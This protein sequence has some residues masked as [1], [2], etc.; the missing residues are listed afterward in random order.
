VHLHPHAAGERCAGERQGRLLLSC[1]ACMALYVFIWCDSVAAW[2][3]PRAHLLH[4]RHDVSRGCMSRTIHP[5]EAAAARYIPNVYTLHDMF[6]RSICC[7]AYSADAAQDVQCFHHMHPMSITSSRSIHFTRHDCNQ[8]QSWQYFFQMHSTCRT[9]T[10]QMRSA[11]RN[12]FITVV[13]RSARSLPR[14]IQHAAH[15]SDT[16]AAQLFTTC[17]LCAM[18][19]PHAFTAHNI[20]SRDALNAECMYQL[21]PPH[22]ICSRCTL[23]T[24]YVPDA[25]TA[26]VIHHP[27][28]PHNIFAAPRIV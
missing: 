2:V 18:C 28:S 9:P 26:H 8:M 12:M 23:R 15:S 13:A 1:R 25:F 16:V 7:T 17:S 6:S 20:Y 19:S 4:S 10:Y 14:W 22:S 24:I 5:P 21:L 11:A 3:Q 27:Y